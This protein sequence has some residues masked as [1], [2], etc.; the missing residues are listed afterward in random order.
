M[1]IKQTGESNTY[2]VFLGE[3]WN[4]WSRCQINP[5]GTVKV[6]KGLPLNYHFLKH[7]QNAVSSIFYGDLRGRKRKE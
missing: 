7:L 2:D 3:G 1:Y 6:V 5:D 4:N